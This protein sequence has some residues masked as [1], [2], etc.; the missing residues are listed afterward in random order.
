MKNLFIYI[1]QNFTVENKVQLLQII[2]MKWNEHIKLMQPQMI[3]KKTMQLGNF[4]M[5]LMETK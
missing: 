2:L 1:I 3:K 4:Q 5:I